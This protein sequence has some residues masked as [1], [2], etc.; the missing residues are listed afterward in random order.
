MA[1]RRP[2][3]A[4]RGTRKKSKAKAKAAR[5]PAAADRP[6][7][8]L[9][10]RVVAFRDARDWKRFHNPKDLAISLSL[11]AAELLEHFQWRDEAAVRRHLGAARTRGQVADEM[12]DVQCLLLALSDATG[13][14]LYEATLRKLRKAARKYP[15]SKAKGTAAK[16]TEL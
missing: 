1:R 8:E 13:I 7:G 4:G 9:L 6:Y 11:E 2:A 12:A 10:R 14:D 3:P 16:Y 15:V 5:S